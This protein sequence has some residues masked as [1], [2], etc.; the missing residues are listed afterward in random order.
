VL[1]ARLGLLP[2]VAHQGL[3][4]PVVHPLHL[5]D[6]HLGGIVQGAGDLAAD[7]AGDQYPFTSPALTA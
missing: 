1:S 6:E 3:A 2:L 4:G 5:A 7:E